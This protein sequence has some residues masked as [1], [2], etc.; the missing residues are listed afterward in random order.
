MRKKVILA[1]G[2]GFLGKALA[3]FLVEKDYEVIILS[4]KAAVSEDHIKYVQWDGRH[5]GEWAREIDGSYAVVNF[6]GKSVNCIYTKKNREEIIA[7]RINSVIVLRDAIK[8][9]KEPPQAFVQAGSLA[10]FGDTRELCDDHSPFGSGFSVEVCKQWEAEFFRESLLTTR[11]VLLRI[12]FALGKDGGALEPLKKLA[13]FNLGGT[14]G[15]GKQYISWLHIDD[16]N[17]MFL[18]SIE[19]ENYK[20]IYNATG[21]TPVTN[22]EFMST[23]RKVIG[24]GW[25]PPAPTPFVWLGAYV[26]MQ[27]EPS[28][29]LTG[30]N[31][32]PKKLVNS[33][34]AFQYTDLEIALKDLIH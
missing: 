33:G 9:S 4:R 2:S 15:S 3:K 1:G 5:L 17:E 29:A 31:C 8:Q 19:N 11:Q 23:L 34:F 30:R 6:T 13:S 18:R 25:S 22:K 7:S 32:I 12:G 27:T 14:V 26:F 16:L 20:G 21:P 10:I 28:L 24:K